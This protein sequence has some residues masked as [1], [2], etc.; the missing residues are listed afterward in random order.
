MDVSIKTKVE[1][2]VLKEGK[3]VLD[4]KIFPEIIRKLP[5]SDVKIEIADNDLVQ[6]SCEKSVLMSFL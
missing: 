3:I 2:T 6:I 4:S 5:N 1:A